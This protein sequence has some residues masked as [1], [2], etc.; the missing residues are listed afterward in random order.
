VQDEQNLLEVR[1]FTFLL[2]KQKIF[3]FKHIRFSMQLKKT[4]GGGFWLP[5]A[6][7]TL[8]KRSTSIFLNRLGS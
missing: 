6:V 4:L 3:F 1:L 2:K 5:R 7:M 8:L